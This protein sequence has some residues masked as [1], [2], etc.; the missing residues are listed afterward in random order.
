MPETRRPARRGPT[1]AKRRAILEA[2]LAVFAARGFARTSV[3]A[4][5][6]RAGVSN[7][8]IYN[9]FRGK[10]DLFQAVIESSATLVADAQIGVVDRHLGAVPGDLAELEQR[11]MAFAVD[12]TTPLPRYEL[13]RALVGQVRAEVGHVPDSV[14][15]AWQQAGPQ[16]VR[17][18]LAD[19]F[20]EFTG[21]GLLRGLDPP[22]A[23]EHFRRLVSLVD[24]LRSRM[25][26]NGE[27]GAGRIADAVHAFLY[28]H[29]ALGGRPR[30]KL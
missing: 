25:A 12:W 23:A 14:I 2:G 26:P 22:V 13:H 6:E 21:A 3:E 17:A 1:A 24:P 9:H 20:A 18:R 10:A 7:R 15:D 27:E 5:A 8:T 28:G 11:L 19:V 30:Q 16:R 4:V 29:A